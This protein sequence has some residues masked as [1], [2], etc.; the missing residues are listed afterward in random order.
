MLVL[1]ASS[2]I[3]GWD[4]YPISHFPKVWEWLASKMA[5]N[6]LTMASVALEEV[7]HVSP[8]CAKWLKAE[9]GLEPVQ[10]NNDIVRTAVAINHLLGIKND[11]YGSGVDENDIFIIATARSLGATLVSNEAIQ[12]S[13]PQKL[14]NYKIPAVCA[15]QKVDVTCIN[16]L[17]L[18][19]KSSMPFA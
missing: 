17:D 2:I 1:D 10:M 14:A 9:S 8:E 7:G 13:R 12:V 6:K 11:H 18:L 16:F 15:M 5:A 4:N 19:K 3:Y